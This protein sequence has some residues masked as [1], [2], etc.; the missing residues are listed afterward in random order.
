MTNHG[1]TM[2][3]II[4]NYPITP[5][6]QTELETRFTYHTPKADQPDRYRTLREASKLMG[7]LIQLACPESREKALAFTN[8]EQACFW[9]NAAIARRE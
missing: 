9:A 6:Q 2:E 8:L 5:A 4:E 3:P 1:G 7:E